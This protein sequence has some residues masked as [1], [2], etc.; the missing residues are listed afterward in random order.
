MVVHQCLVDPRT[1][2]LSG[3]DHFIC[4]SFYA[5]AV[6]LDRA[7][8]RSSRVW[9]AL[10]IAA[11][12]FILPLGNDREDIAIVVDGAPLPLGIRIILIHRFNQSKAFV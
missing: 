5:T 6:A 3:L 10:S 9:M 12:V 4:S 11:T 7:F 8:E 2:L 1:N